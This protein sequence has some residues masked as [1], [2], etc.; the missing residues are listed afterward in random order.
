[1]QTSPSLIVMHHLPDDGSKL[2]YLQ[3]NQDRLASGG[4]IIHADMCFDNKVEHARLVPVWRAH[5]DLVDVSP[6]ATR[7][8]FDAIPHLM[9]ASD[10]RTRAQINV[11]ALD[12]MITPKTKL[13]AITPVPTQCGL[14]NPAAEIG[15]V[16][17][18]HDVLYLL[19][20]CQ[21]VGQIHV[22]VTEISCDILSGTGRKFLRGPRGTGFLY[23]RKDI[24][25]RIDPPFID[26]SSATW[27]ETNDFNFVDGAKRF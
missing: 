4:R 22:D 25:E 17:R 3:S 11:D 27:S 12:H 16:A 10:A 24:I 23:V 20:A 7:L 13:I 5:A 2:A 19:D 1:M 14:V 18:K 9:V 26:P 21:S 8:E 15:K 6:E